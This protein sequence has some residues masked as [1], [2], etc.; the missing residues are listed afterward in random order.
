MTKAELVA[1]IADKASTTKANAERALNAFLEAVEA[2][3]V[4]EGKLTLTGFGTFVVE[5]RKA[6]TGRNPRTGKAITIPSTKV[7]KFRPGKL[8]KDAVK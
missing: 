1:K 6:R 7:V 4:K 8:L 2:T 5:E 3:L